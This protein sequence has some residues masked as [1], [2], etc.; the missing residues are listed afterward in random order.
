MLKRTLIATALLSTFS[1]SAANVYT[2]TSTTEFD[3]ADADAGAVTYSIEGSQNSASYAVPN[4]MVKLGAEYQVGD[5]ITLAFNA[6]L[7]A[8]L[9]PTA[10]QQDVNVT[11]PTAPTY[12]ATAT[13]SED[14][15]LGLLSVNDNTVTFR[16][17]ARNASTAGAYILFA[18][19]EVDDAAAEAVDGIEVTYSASTSTGITIDANAAN[20]VE[21]ILLLKD[22][23]TSSVDTKA[24]QEVNVTGGRV[25][26]VGA[27]TTDAATRQDAIIVKTTRTAGL[28]NSA[29]IDKVVVKVEG[30]FSW[31][32]DT[33]DTTT[34]V[35]EPVSGVVTITDPTF[36][37][38]TAGAEVVS[39]VVTPTSITYTQTFT[40]EGSI[41][42][43]SYTITLDPSANTIT[44]VTAP[45]L[46]AGEYTA[47]STITYS[48]VDGTAAGTDTVSGLD[49]GE[50]TLN[51]DTAV[52]Y[53]Y[54]VSSAVEGFIW[55]T[56]NGSLAG[57]ISVTA[58][59]DGEVID[60]GTVGTAAANSATRIGPAI[61]AALADKDI[62]SGRV[63]LNIT[64][65][66]PST[67]LFVSASYKVT[68][69]ADRLTLDVKN[70]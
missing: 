28:S 4:V 62:T 65:N 15:S 69:D 17:T 46:S 67:K 49:A 59:A 27:L 56:N 25:A 18:G 39:T 55:V 37:A 9:T 2:V 7:A 45:V 43:G 61:D 3:P 12:A 10:A 13:G 29:V 64:T 16:V 51:G 33:D 22:E 8:D 19:L 14:I 36:T 60:L 53:A 23:L 57:D 35:I 5:T 42:A 21:G 54:P 40:G 6:N 1:A 20:T 48:P 63:Q 26:F 50:W 31:I 24:D 52:V 11:V 66:A 34:D 47:S 32:L 38:G 70:D 41:A 30:D 68:A 58:V 44:G